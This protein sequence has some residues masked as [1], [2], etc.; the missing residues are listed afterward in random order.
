MTRE[1]R[2]IE[3]VLPSEVGYERVAMD[4][5][6]ALAKI[7]GFP[8]ARIEDLKTAVA[9][10][11]LNAMQHG[12]RDRPGAR[13]RMT[14]GFEKDEIHVQVMDEGSGIADL[15][16][17]PETEEAMIQ[18]DPPRGLGIFLIRRLVDAVDFNAPTDKGH[19]VKM[20]I[21]REDCMPPH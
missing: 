5:A 16:D 1:E 4:G 13:V 11:C 18:S 14:L 20:L 9:E 19:A 2:S 15:P 6:G 12:N 3:L 10:A 7:L 8:A 17:S 21:R